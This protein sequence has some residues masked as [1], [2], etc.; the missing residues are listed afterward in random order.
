[1]MALSPSFCA[2]FPM[3][4][5]SWHFSPPCGNHQHRLRE[6]SATYDGRTTTPN[7]ALAQSQFRRFS[8]EILCPTAIQ[9]MGDHTNYILAELLDLQCCPMIWVVDFSA[10]L[11]RFLVLCQLQ[12]VFR[13]PID[14][15]DDKLQLRLHLLHD[16]QASALWCREIWSESYGQNSHLALRKQLNGPHHP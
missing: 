16:I 1:M 11:P 5:S 3:Q 6:I 15:F 7:Q 14:E 10:N 9:L 2:T 8:P 4:V 13:L 12:V